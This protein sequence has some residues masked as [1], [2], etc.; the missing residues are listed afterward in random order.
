MRPAASDFSNNRSKQPISKEGIAMK[1]TPVMPADLQSSVIAVPPLCLD[2]SGRIDRAQ[3][4]RLIDHLL[5]GGITTFMYGGNANF[6]NMPLADMEDFYEFAESLDCADAWILPAVGPDYGNLQIQTALV[7]ASRFPTVMVLPMAAI[8]T[9]AGV[10]TGIRRFSDAIGRPVILYIK[11]EGYITPE[12]AGRLAADG[13][14]AGIKYAIV[15]EDPTDDAYLTRLIETVDRNLII[16]GIGE[17]PVI[18]HWQKFGLRSFTSG[19]CCV[20]PAL[21][22]AI[23]KALQAGDIARAEEIRAKFIP[24]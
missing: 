11:R 13:I 16:S 3:N 20:A 7:K 24:F 9:S 23:L 2:E 14:I 4:R 21:S 22:T 1:T 5:G 6:Y 19:S 17:R 10:A 12:D 8:S 15:R 18:V